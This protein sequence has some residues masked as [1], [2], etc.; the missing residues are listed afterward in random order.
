MGTKELPTYELC[1]VFSEHMTEP[2]I[3]SPGV[4]LPIQLCSFLYKT[5][6]PRMNLFRVG[7]AMVFL[8]RIAPKKAVE[9]LFMCSCPLWT[10]NSPLH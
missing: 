1:G 8:S 6:P 2:S 9:W 10:S 5:L 4:H 3:K 7:P